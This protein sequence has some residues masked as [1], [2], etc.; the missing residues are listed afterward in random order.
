MIQKRIFTESSLKAGLRRGIAFAAAFFMAAE[1]LLPQMPVLADENDGNP[2]QICVSGNETLSGND[3]K[4][5]G[6]VPYS[7]SLAYLYAEQTLVE[8]GSG[9]RLMVSLLEERRILSAELE[10]YNKDTLKVSETSLNRIDGSELVFDTPALPAGR[11]GFGEL[12]LHFEDGDEVLDISGI[13]GLENAGIG[14]G[15]DPGLEADRI[16]TLPAE[17]EEAVSAEGGMSPEGIVS[18]DLASSILPSAQKKI[19]DAITSQTLQSG[20]NTDELSAEGAKGKVVIVLDPGH[21][22]THAGARSHGLTEEKLTLTVANYC[23]AY[24]EKNYSNVTVYLTRTSGSC[25]YPGNT[26][27]QDNAFRVD[28][29]ARACANAYVSIHFNTTGAASGTSAGAM[30]FYPNA[31]YNASVSSS[32]KTLASAIQAKLV[33]LGLRNNGVRTYNSQSGDTY[34]DGSLADYY[35]VIRRSKLYGFPGIII[36]HAFLNNDSDAVFCSSDANLKKL[37]EA[38]AQG[39]AEAFGLKSG[40]AEDE[41]GKEVNREGFELS[42]SLNAKQT[43]ASFTLTGTDSSDKNVYFNVYSEEDDMDDLA[44][45]YGKKQSS[46]KWTGSCMIKDHETA[47]KYMVFAYTVNSKGKATKVATGTFTVTGPSAESVKIA[48]VK[49]NKGTFQVRAQKVAAPSGIEQVQIQVT[50]QSGKK[51]AELLTAKKKSGYYYVTVKLANHGYN[52]GKYRVE[53]IVKDKTG[54]INKAID[55]KLD[56]GVPTPVVSAKLKSKQTKLYMKVTNAGI[57]SQV[58]GVKFKV[59]SVT[60]K[61]S[62]TYQAK[63]GS[64]GTYSLTAKISD[65]AAAGKY[66][67]TAYRKLKGGKYTKIG[68]TKTITVAGIEGGVATA[69]A[70]GSSGNIL[71]VS[72]FKT[73]A[74]ISSVTVKAWPKVKKAAAYTYKAEKEDDIWTAEINYKNHAKKKGTY[75]YEITVKLKNGISKLALKGSFTLGKDP[76]L[77]V[78]EGDT[79]VTLDQ[80]V[81]YYE[82]HATYPVYYQNSDATTIRK[83]CKIYLDECKTEGI[84]AEVAFCQAMKETNFLRFG[85]DVKISQYNF[86]GLGATGGGA[87]GNSYDSVRTGIRAQVQ[88]LKAYASDK[89]LVNSCV[90][91]RFTYVT[92]K[93][94]PYVEWLGIQENPAHKGWATDPGYGQSIVNMI[95]ELSGY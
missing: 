19:R 86:A 16:A 39:I 85:G 31:N 48:S 88:H 34:P 15:C 83:F 10:L 50:N 70:D 37:G 82:A 51:Q 45:Y 69:Q 92:R 18:M 27:T 7:G 26:S 62:K 6:P 81:D 65:F 72:G 32:G 64:G 14:V 47:G 53:V 5:E 13:S 61:K 1:L 24:L 79:S 42:V 52:T 21:D 66:K 74:N 68:E 9:T 94:A 77:Y 38:D 46:S 60:A 57:G 17:E 23:K 76:D 75:K 12:T 11:Y 55:E 91:D 56:L 44:T 63:K 90:D 95:G 29:A 87:A 20:Q 28:A 58:S 59:K 89:A 3:V 49:L 54:I 25:P 33:K 93:C 71:S 80:M 43:K 2:S 22:D 4:E 35:G 36:E 67:I 8:A 73:S 40:A 30:V 41:N 78:I 84:K